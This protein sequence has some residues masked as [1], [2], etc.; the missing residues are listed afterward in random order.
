MLFL[1]VLESESLRSRDQHVYVLVRTCFLVVTGVSLLC[2]HMGK[3]V[4]E[5][6]EVLFLR[7]WYS[8]GLHPHEV[9]TSQRPHVLILPSLGV[10]ISTYEFMGDTN[11]WTTA[12]RNFKYKSNDRILKK[13]IYTC[14]YEK[15]QKL[16][17]LKCHKIKKKNKLGNISN[18]YD[19]K[20]ISLT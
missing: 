1:T 14:I 20:I 15:I 6:C 8:P 18:K 10:R 13:K 3:G 17:R 2:P 11:I 7:H 12:E 4:R 5:L 9:I 19:N 16:F